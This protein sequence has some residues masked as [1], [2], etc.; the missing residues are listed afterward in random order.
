MAR[1]IVSRPRN[2][3]NLAEADT[4][5]TTELS[6]AGS[7]ARLAAVRDPGGLQILLVDDRPENLRALEAVLDPLGLP[8]ISATSGSQALRLLLEHDFAVILLDVRMPG[9]DGLETA[10]LIK[11]RERNRDIPIV[12]LTAAQDDVGDIVRGYEVGAVDYVLKPFDADLLRSKVAIFVELQERRRALQRSEALL[13]GAFEYAPI[14][15][16]VLDADLRIVRSNPA[17]ARLVGRDQNELPGLDVVQLCHPED[18]RALAA[19]LRGVATGEPG[20]AAP[21]A[22]GVDLRLL[23]RPGV[24][25]WVGLVG[26]AVDPGDLEGGHLLAQWI[27]LS[28][29]R[30]A[31]EARAE[32]LL[33]QSARTH[34]EAMADR[35]NKLQEL[36]DALETLSLQ[37]LLGEL[38]TRVAEMFGADA[39]EVRVGDEHEQ[40][41]VVRTS[42]GR[43]LADGEDDAVGEAPTANEEPNGAGW[44]RAPMRIERRRIGSVAVHLPGRRSL[45]PAEL[46]LLHGAAERSALSIRQARLFEE[47]HRIARELQRGLLPKHL[48]DVPGLELAAHYQAGGTAAEEVGGDWYDAFALADGR[49]GIV[50]GDV[51]GRGIPAASTM[52]QMRSVTRAYAL[53]EQARRLPAEVLTR[54]NRYQLVLQ[55]DQ[56]FTV[57]YAVLDPGAGTVTWANAGHLPPLIAGSSGT[58]AYLPGG[59][60]PIGVEDVEYRNLVEPL[61]PGSALVLYTDGLVERRGESLDA[62]FE[63]LAAAA[64]EAPAAPG[65]LCRFLLSRML[66]EP[67][68]LH[69]DVTLVLARSLA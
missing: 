54:L 33:E 10:R 56:L 6:E 45:K 52:G 11:T 4:H 9:I 16:T 69:D 44:V 31:E 55:E 39:S 29:R 66:P 47:E 7:A 46:S 27:D 40:P 32:L 43:V 22:G 36:A 8:L 38:A 57:L 26:S 62:G 1:R 2:D 49:V 3:P 13:R 37:E 15:K 67:S 18:R 63:R 35:L 53:T 5:P 41:I 14:G 28:V 58:V 24:E 48:P 17:F 42:G 19:A 30:R 59:G 34:A 61:E 50:V 68:E 20:A 60:Y 12:F 65:E 21:D 23:T 51:A 64:A 25:V